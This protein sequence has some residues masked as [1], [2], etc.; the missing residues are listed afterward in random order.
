VV[1]PL[2]L[3]LALWASCVLVSGCA[4][5]TGTSVAAPSASASV[6]AASSDSASPSASASTAPT[7][8]P[9]ATAT[10]APAPAGRFAFG[11]SVMLGSKKLLQTRGFIVDA[12]VGRQFGASYNAVVKLRR[13]HR[14]PANIVVHLGTN[15]TIA[16]RDCKAL[17][18]AV[19]PGRRVFLVN[20]RVPRPWTHGNNVTIGR[21][22]AAFAANRVVVVDWAGTANGHREWFGADNVHPDAVGRTAYVRLIDDAVT[23]Q[24]L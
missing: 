4:A 13:G 7:A 21:C 8:T 11:D 3:P 23:T 16:L 19:G 5:S 17:V 12:K 20:V 10:D 14:L 18:D 15:G 1:R 6:S 2:V 9:S 24:G 22:D